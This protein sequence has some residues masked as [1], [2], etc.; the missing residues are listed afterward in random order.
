LERPPI[1][2]RIRH[3]L[4]ELPAALSRAPDARAGVLLLADEHGDSG[5][6]QALARALEA[7]GFAVL[8][9]ELDPGAADRPTLLALEAAAALLARE[10]RLDARRVAALGI[11]RG[12]TLALL[13]A[14]TGTSVH[15]LVT[16]DAP[17]LYGELCA[18]RPIQPLELVLNLGAPWLAFFDAGGARVPREEVERLRRSLAAAGKHHELVVSARSALPVLPPRGTDALGAR[19]AL[20]APGL[21]RTLC[22]LRE[23][24]EP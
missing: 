15:A 20:E 21:E 6:A 14:C 11:G 13:L 2:I 12:G 4:G 8:A 3:A 23:A 10:A 16:V 7:A 5:E 9:P 17:L 22:F 19:H 24:L 1:P 18:A